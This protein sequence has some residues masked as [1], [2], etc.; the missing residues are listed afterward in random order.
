[1]SFERNRDVSFFYFIFFFPLF[2]LVFAFAPALLFFAL[3]AARLLLFFGV[4]PA[5]A[6]VTVRGFAFAA[7]LPGLRIDFH[8]LLRY[9]FIYLFFFNYATLKTLASVLSTLPFRCVS[10]SRLAYHWGTSARPMP[11]P[12]APREC[13]SPRS[14]SHAD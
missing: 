3:D 13:T 10:V 4:Q 6:E 9:F 1:M 7:L 11:L 8:L 14:T 2:L 12:V 5:G